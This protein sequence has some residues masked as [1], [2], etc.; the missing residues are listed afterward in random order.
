[1][2][3]LRRKKDAPAVKGGRPAA[4][5]QPRGARAK[6]IAAAFTATRKADPRMPL[7]VAAALLAPI[8]VA[9]VVGLVL[10]GLLYLLPLGILVGL[11]LAV[12]VFGQRVQRTA[13]GQVEGQL[14]AAAAVLTNMRGDWRVTPAVGFT[15]EQDLVHRV[16]GRPGIVLVAEGSASRT[17]GLIVNEK[18]RLARFVG[19]TP[20]YDVSVGE[21]EGQLTLR[22]LEKHFI[23]LPRNITP[24]EVNVLDRKLKAMAPPLP[25]PKGP[26]PTRVPRGK[27]R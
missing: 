17:R 11:L 21:G 15:R 23:K 3:S 25:A 26:V 13:Y 22:G 20:V 1:M 19:T 4:P 6:Q 16:V 14:G 27:G 8:L 5:K 24:K 9:L 2:V 7:L 12:T 18:K 10:G